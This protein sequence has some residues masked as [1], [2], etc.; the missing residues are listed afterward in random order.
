M[1]AKRAAARTCAGITPTSAAVAREMRIII[2]E[3][4]IGVMRAQAAQILSYVDGTPHAAM[5]RLGARRS[6][7]QP[8]SSRTSQ[9]LCLFDDDLRVRVRAQTLRGAEASA[10][11]PH[12]NKIDYAHTAQDRAPAAFAG[13]GGASP[14]DRRGGIGG[15]ANNTLGP[16][17]VSSSR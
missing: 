14:H 6:A 11:G 9:A 1:F 7:P 15:N 8:G 5:A 16:Y 13:G 10:A 12:P 3:L 17:A 2:R 4:G